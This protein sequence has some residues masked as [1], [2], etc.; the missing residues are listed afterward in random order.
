M[1]RL[2][3]TA[4]ALGL[5]APAGALAP[6]ARAQAAAPAGVPVRDHGLVG[7]WFAPASGR[8]GPVIL[9]LGGSEGG[10]QTVKRLG[11]AFAAQGYGVL[12]LAWFGAEGLPPHLQEIP[13]EYFGR[14]IDWIEA[15]PLA[16]A[17]RIGLYGVSKGG[18]AALLIASRH[19]EIKA[20]A[21][22]VPSSVVWQGI[23]MTDWT[24]VKSSFSLDGRPVAFVPY[25]ASAPFT[26]VLDLYERSLR[27]LDKHPEAAIPVERIAGPVLLLSGRQDALWPSSAMADQVIARLDAKGFK[28]PHR[29]LAY[30]EAGHVGVVPPLE[31]SGGGSGAAPPNPAFPLGGTP[32]GN[33]AARA[34]AWAQTLAFFAEALGGPSK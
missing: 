3:V 2:A 7:T 4:F 11:A 23:N 5:L 10:E 13:L 17:G 24:S 8:R 20:V 30:A 28:H 9:V 34:E 18:E 25:D 22:A 21:A 19:S 26:T 6:A 31:A 14:A 16:D 1:L 12:A 33:K 32:E 29:H 15:Q 27:H